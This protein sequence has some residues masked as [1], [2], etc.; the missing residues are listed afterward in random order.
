M[1]TKTFMAGISRFSIAKKDIATL[2]ENN[3]L[4]VFGIHDIAAILD[5]H[6][7]EW[8]LAQ[9]MTTEKFIEELI[10]KTKLQALTFPFLKKSFGPAFLKFFEALDLALEKIKFLRIYS[11]KVVFVFSKPKK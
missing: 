7:G 11:F 1:P 2:F 5:K 6:R 4:K 8:R 3:P 9:S 10:T